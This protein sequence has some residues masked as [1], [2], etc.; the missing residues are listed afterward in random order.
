MSWYLHT[1]GLHQSS[2]LLSRTALSNIIKGVTKG[3][4][5]RLRLTGV[6]YRATV[7]NG[8]LILNAGYSQIIKVVI[9]NS[10]SLQCETSTN[11]LISGIKKDQVGNFASK[12]R[13]IRAPEPYKGKG[14]S[15]EN[16]LIHRK[17]G[18]TGK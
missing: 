13:L 9:P 7:E 18:K 2:L 11:L 3:F 10:I 5:K 4:Q 15:Y 8:C 17:P 6:G 16:E 1:P 14:I 12:I